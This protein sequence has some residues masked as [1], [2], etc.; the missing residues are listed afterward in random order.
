MPR[1]SLFVNLL[2]AL[3]GATIGSIVA[4]RLRQSVVVGY[5]VAGIVIGPFTPGFVGDTQTV[6]A[7]ADIGIVLL[8]F[9]IGVQLSL[10]E[11][12]RVGR[13]AILGG[14]AQVIIMIGL[15]YAAGL[16]FGWTQLEALFF[17]AVLSNSS[18]TVIS[19]VLGERGELDTWHARVSLAWSTVQDVST[20]L[21]V[22]ILSSLS[23]G[24][25]INV[26]ELLWAIGRT[27]LFL[28]LL[29]PLGLYVLPRLFERVA[30][31]RS[32]EV[33]VLTVAA[34]ALGTAFSASLFGLSL[35]LGAF[36][37]GVVVGESDLSHRIL[38]E[39]MPI[40][41]IFAGLFFVS[42]G[43]LVNPAFAVQ[44]FGLL[45]LTVVL[46]VVVKVLLVTG[47]IT[48]AGYHYR[49]AIMAAV[50]LGQCAEFSFL[51]A[52]LG[53][54]LGAIGQAAFSVMLTGSVASIVLVPSL[55]RAAP[56]VGS[57][58]EQRV[59]APRRKVASSVPGVTPELRGHAVICGFG[60]VGRT[61]A[62]ALTRRDFPFSVIDEDQGVVRRFREQGGIAL[63][64]NAANPALLEQVNLPRARVLVI[65]I[66]DPL[67]TRQ[68]V[69]HAREIN[70]NLE[71]IARTHNLAERDYLE[72]HGVAKGVV[73]QIELALELTQ[74][75]LRRFG[76]SVTETLAIISG[77]RTRI[78]EREL[79]DE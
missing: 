75:T 12:L 40:R 52:R 20:V 79:P 64:G 69:D 56:S 63:L 13:L 29:A 3:G 15:G 68:I 46:I 78:A 19:K 67:A 6:E 11:L 55:Q 28:A 70:P 1:E 54:D 8:L 27:V 50:A 18:S 43:M 45:L 42:V 51:L 39:L 37:A 2:A 76:V 72:E 66:P 41:D 61:V 33:F 32:R 25:G 62:S 5:I 48:F 21:L 35:A 34:V 58:V 57:W 10:R 44:H 22:I 24:E 23:N 9:A 73:G 71:I 74:H 36:V 47:I 26:F 77:L 53:A 38:G 14:S 49:P 59:P 17:G 16:L 4:A 30:A 31:L 7:L 60:W 65:A